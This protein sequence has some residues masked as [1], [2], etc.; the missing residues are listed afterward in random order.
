MAR[1]FYGVPMQLPDEL[2]SPRVVSVGLGILGALLSMCWMTDLTGP[3]KAGAVATGSVVA[4]LFAPPIIDLVS[5]P[6]GWSNA[7]SFLVGGIGWACMGKL[8]STIRGADIW[9]LASDI[10]RSW[11]RRKG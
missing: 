9:G 6:A 11:L 3:Q 1:F 4:A 7:I 10:I 2:K 5:A 8:I